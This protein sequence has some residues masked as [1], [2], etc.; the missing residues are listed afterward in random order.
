[1][2]TTTE[3]QRKPAPARTDPWLRY[4]PAFGMMKQDLD[5]GIA[6]LMLHDAT[7][8]FEILGPVATIN[9]GIEV[10]RDDFKRRLDA[11]DHGGDPV[12]PEVYRIW[13]RDHDGD[14]TIAYEVRESDAIL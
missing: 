7:G 14:Y 13:A 4:H 2:K 5:L 6:I 11:L 12:C 1:M 3:R 10:A 9:E 8:G